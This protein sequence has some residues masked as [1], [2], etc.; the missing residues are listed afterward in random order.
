MILGNGARQVK[1]MNIHKVY[2]VFQKY[3]REKRML[4]FEEHFKVSDASRILDVGGGQYNWQFLSHKPSIRVM[5][6]VKPANW[7]DRLSQFQFEVGDGMDINYPDRSFD[8]VYSNSVIEHLGDWESQKLFAK[9]ILRVGKSV[10]V[11]TPAKEFLV[12][13][14]LLTPFIHWL[15]L[16]WQARL[17]RNFSLWGVITR[18]SREYVDMF[19]FERRLLSF[20]EFKELFKGCE[21]IH[22]KVSVFTKSHIAVKHSNENCFRT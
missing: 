6:I 5:N 12:E 11:Q 10:Y 20:R 16:R 17:L 7:D 14:H 8:I 15:P 3:F 19:L 21:I 13:P 4:W 18:P 2:G 9:E 22:E 1:V